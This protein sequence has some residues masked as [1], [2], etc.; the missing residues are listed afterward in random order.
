MNVPIGTKAIDGKKITAESTK[1]DLH[2]F[3]EG[4]NQGYV[5]LTFQG[6]SGFEEGLL[7]VEGSAVVASY[8]TYLGLGKE[9]TGGEALEHCLNAFHAP[10]GVYDVFI[11]TAQQIELLKVFNEDLLLLEG[12][13]FA[14]LESLIPTSF[15]TA[16][17]DT[18][19]GAALPDKSR[20]DIMKE[21]SLAEIKIDSYDAV[22]KQMEV[23]VEAPA[24]PT[25]VAKQLEDYIS[26]GGGI[27]EKSSIKD[28]EISTGIIEKSKVRSGVNEPDE[29]N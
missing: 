20:E 19:M 29:E 26:G 1:V 2:Q 27:V 21:K 4:R 6:K 7:V 15:S 8:Y 17:L 3:L 12:K 24:A 16:Y 22:R 9:Y 13:N 5:C 10:N 14:A 23:P 11:L 28:S 18:A 25:K